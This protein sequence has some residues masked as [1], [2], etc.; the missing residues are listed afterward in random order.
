M[1]S[2]LHFSMIYENIKTRGLL[3][4]CIV[5]LCEI[6]AQGTPNIL[7][8]VFY[9]DVQMTKANTNGKGLYDELYYTCL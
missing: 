4:C 3:F 8:L 2:I 9:Q 1:F 5:E 7:N 6:E